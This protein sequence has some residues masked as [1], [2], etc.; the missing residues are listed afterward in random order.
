MMRRRSCWATRGAKAGTRGRLG[1]VLARLASGV[2]FAVGTGFSDRERGDPPAIGS[3][4]TFRY[5]EL[6]DAGVPRFPS[7]VGVRTDV[8]PV[9]VP[10]VND[11]SPVSAGKAPPIALSSAPSA[12]RAEPRHFELLDGKSSKFWEVSQ[13]GCDMTTRWGRIGTAGQS[14]TKSFADPAA[15]QDQMSRLIEE[16]TREGYVE[17]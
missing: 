2:E 17:K 9:G 7:Y 5:Q 8:P 3:T 12:A 6:S 16:K 11:P 14:K 15:A 10:T 4:I 13:S 1:A